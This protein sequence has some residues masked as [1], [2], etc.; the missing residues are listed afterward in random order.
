MILLLFTSLII[1]IWL[2]IFVNS[3][4]KLYYS[5]VWATKQTRHLFTGTCRILS[6]SLLYVPKSLLILYKYVFYLILFLLLFCLYFSV[7]QKLYLKYHNNLLNLILKNT[8]DKT[9]QNS[10]EIHATT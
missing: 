6:N 2:P 3:L 8:E 9:I 10:S 7:L 1:K 5:H 4:R